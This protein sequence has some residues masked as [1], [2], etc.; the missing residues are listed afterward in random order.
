[1][2]MPVHRPR[3]LTLKL[4]RAFLITEKVSKERV[5]LERKKGIRHLLLLHDVYVD[6]GRYVLLC[7]LDDGGAQVDGLLLL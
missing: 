7:H 1:M 3:E 4:F 5:V 6:D 2:I